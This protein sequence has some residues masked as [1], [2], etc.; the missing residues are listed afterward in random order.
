MTSVLSA[1]HFHDEEAAYDFLEAS[2]AERPGLPALRRIRS[3]FEDGA[4][5]APALAS[6]KCYQ[7]RMQFT[8]KV[9]TVFESS[10]VKLNI[11]LQ[12]VAL[13]SSSKKGISSNQLHR[14]LGV[15]S[16]P[17]GSC[18]IVF[19]RPCAMASWPRWAAAARSWKWTKPTFGR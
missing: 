13:L 15:R 4:A 18:P 16:K 17:H 1:K 9:G 12:A 8:V 7:C 6:Y 19:A 2:L 14:T 3:H 10:H 5:R 11:W